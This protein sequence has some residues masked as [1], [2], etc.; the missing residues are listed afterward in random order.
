MQAI[1]WLDTDVH[2]LPIDA[3]ALQS[4]K[5][6]LGPHGVGWLYIRRSLVEQIEP[7]A[8]G[9]RSMTLRDSFLDH[10]FELSDTATRFETGVLNLHGIAGVGANLDLLDHI[11]IAAIEARVL[12]L[13]DRLAEGLAA[14]GY[15]IA[16][17]RT[18]ARQRSAIVVFRHPRIEPSTC[19]RRLVEA[20]VVVS[21]REGAVRASPHFYNNEDDI[22]RLLAALP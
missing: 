19:H 3:M 22:D 7:L 17:A 5:W 18:N 9:S 8:V 16:G 4:Y 14:R 11:G 13:T 15:E 2:R 21:L 1:G 12:S 6:L 10:R 20:S